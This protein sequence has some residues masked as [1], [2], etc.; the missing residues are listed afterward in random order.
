MVGHGG[1]PIVVE[2]YGGGGDGVVHID[3]STVFP[4]G[5]PAGHKGEHALQF[6]VKRGVHIA[7]LQS[8]GHA[9][10]ADDKVQGTWLALACALSICRKDEMLAKEGVERV[11]VTRIFRHLVG[12]GNDGTGGRDAVAVQF[13]S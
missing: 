2:M 10:G 4:R 9:V 3:R 1:V 7:R 11:V 13:L 8:A 5:N 12:V 6:A